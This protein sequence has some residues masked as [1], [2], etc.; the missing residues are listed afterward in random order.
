MLWPCDEDQKPRNFFRRP[1]SLF[2]LRELIAKTDTIF[3]KWVESF[4]LATR[5]RESF[6]VESWYESRVWDSRLLFAR[7]WLILRRRRCATRSCL[8]D[9]RT[10]R[11]CVKERGTR[12]ASNADEFQRRNFNFSILLTP[13]IPRRFEPVH[14][15]KYFG[16]RAFTSYDCKYFPMLIATQCGQP[17]ETLRSNFAPNL[18]VLTSNT[19]KHEFSLETF[20]YK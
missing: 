14:L 15:G 11:V 4:D 8:D 3:P 5:N 9:A 19:F 20:S 6:R 17:F 12:Y 7:Q 10:G 13:R 18:I 16:I 1:D 2:E